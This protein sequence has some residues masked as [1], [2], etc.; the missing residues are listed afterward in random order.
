ME[1][2]QAEATEADDP[3]LLGRFKAQV[4]VNIKAVLGGQHDN[5]PRPRTNTIATPAPE[6]RTPERGMDAVDPGLLPEL[7][8]AG[9]E[10]AQKSRVSP[11]PP[12]MQ[13]AISEQTLDEMIRDI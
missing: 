7:S 12:A 13:V 2:W 3:A 4:V 10:T 8:L 5:S 6:V 1:V 9:M 11:L